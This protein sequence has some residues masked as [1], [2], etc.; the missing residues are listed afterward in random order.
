MDA[1]L[2]SLRSFTFILFGLI[3][4]RASNSPAKFMPDLAFAGLY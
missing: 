2:Q 1:R 4:G 3:A